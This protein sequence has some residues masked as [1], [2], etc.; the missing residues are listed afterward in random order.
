MPTKMSTVMVQGVKYGNHGYV[1][2][3][4]LSFH[5]PQKSRPRDKINEHVQ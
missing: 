2:Y 3:L 1:A 4:E 5:N